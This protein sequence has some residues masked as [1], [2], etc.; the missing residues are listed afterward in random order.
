MV[1]GTFKTSRPQDGAVQKFVT[2]SHSIRR[3]IPKPKPSWIHAFPASLGP[4]SVKTAAAMAA[5]FRLGTQA[6]LPHPNLRSNRH[7]KSI[8]FDGRLA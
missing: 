4:K 5:N 1:S 8:M 7:G 3:Q 6:N 2:S